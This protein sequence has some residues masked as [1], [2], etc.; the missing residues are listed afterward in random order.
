M[1]ELAI[2][3]AVVGFILL[4]AIVVGS[5]VGLARHLAVLDEQMYHVA[6][7]LDTLVRRVDEGR[8][9]TQVVPQ[10]IIEAYE[11]TLK[12]SPRLPITSEQEVARPQSTPN[13]A[14]HLRGR[15]IPSFASFVEEEDG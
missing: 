14:A 8:H 11:R 5:Y 12:S 1:G 15:G 3:V 9:A 4:L 2:F 7:R 13:F 6:E 10:R